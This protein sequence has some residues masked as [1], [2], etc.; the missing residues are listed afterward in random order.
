MNSVAK[1]LLITANTRRWRKGSRHDTQR[2]TTTAHERATLDH[3]SIILV[4][5]FLKVLTSFTTMEKQKNATRA[6]TQDVIL[7]MKLK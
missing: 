1:L 5:V 7:I 3:W 2:S 4:T 6:M